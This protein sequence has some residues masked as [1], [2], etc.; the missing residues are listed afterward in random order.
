[1]RVEEIITNKI[2]GLLEQG[3]VPWHRPWSNHE[4]PKNLVTKKEYRGIN[5]FMLSAMGFGSP[6]WA[7]FKQVKE[8]GGSVK[9]DQHG[10][11]VVFWKWIE[12]KE[13]TEDGDI[14]IKRIPYL[15]Y[16]TVFNIEQTE[17]IDEKKIPA[18]AV[19]YNNIERI[20]ACEGTVANMP[21]RPQIVHRE[22]RAYYQ[23][24]KDIVN[25]PKLESFDG[26][27]EYYSTLFHEL[28]HSTG[29][30]TRLNR[31][32][33]NG[34]EGEWSVFGSVPY[35]KEELV[36]ELG[37]AF[38]CGY[39]QIEN[40]TIDNSASYIDSWLSKLRKDKTL[41]VHAAAQAQRAVDFI[42]GEHHEE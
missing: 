13:E 27:E 19:R 31:K 40:K 3:T 35:A 37:A 15:R 8:L 28:V 36:A 17:D 38:L 10:C 41:I 1:M 30:Q 14:T 32:G 20:E 16:Y 21:K 22:Q 24:V 39:S 23:P 26:A 7:S 9:K 34:T 2:I 12:K 11:P 29:H 6:F 33:V 4:V 18:L 5:V 25:L 42:R